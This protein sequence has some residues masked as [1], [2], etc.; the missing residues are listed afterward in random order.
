MEGVVLVDSRD[1]LAAITLRLIND[2]ENPTLTTF[3]V[4]EGIAEASMMAALKHANRA[5]KPSGR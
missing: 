1:P 5:G 2:P 4:V 3:P